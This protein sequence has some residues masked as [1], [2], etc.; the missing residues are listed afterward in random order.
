M[1]ASVLERELYY[2]ERRG[3]HCTREEVFAA[4]DRILPLE[5]KKRQAL[6]EKAVGRI[7]GGEA[8]PGTGR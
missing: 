7:R 3:I 8:A 6:G 1:D 2:L 4:L 5:R